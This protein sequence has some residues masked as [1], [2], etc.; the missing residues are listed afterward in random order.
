MAPKDTNQPDKSAEIE[1][2]ENSAEMG[3][4]PLFRPGEKAAGNGKREDPPE[5]GEEEGGLQ[6]GRTASPAQQEGARE[7]AGR[8]PFVSPHPLE[9]G[10]STASTRAPRRQPQPF[11]PGQQAAWIAAVNEI[12]PRRLAPEPAAM[13]D[14][15]LGGV[16]D[17]LAM[18]GEADAQANAFWGCSRRAPCIATCGHHRSSRR[19]SAA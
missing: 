16:W 15:A 17:L 7:A 10:S 9:E 18:Q 2:T 8:R 5:S 14:H 6:R 12:D 3:V 13:L 4:Q 19:C 1:A 11:L